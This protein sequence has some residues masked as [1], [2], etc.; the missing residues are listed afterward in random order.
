M[1]LSSLPISEL[2]GFYV[3]VASAPIPCHAPAL[4]YLLCFR[5]D[6]FYFVHSFTHLP[7]L[8]VLMLLESSHETISN[9]SVKKYF[10]CVFC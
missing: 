7:L 3:A 9:F 1:C 6:L 10:V 5:G 8:L 4:R 2:G